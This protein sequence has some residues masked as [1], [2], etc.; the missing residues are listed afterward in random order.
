MT[1]EQPARDVRQVTA[2]ETGLVR[3]PEHL[4]IVAGLATAVSVCG[5]GHC[6]A[7]TPDPRPAWR[8]NRP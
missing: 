3:L 2:D 6:V 1:I 8:C 4:L 7:Q 5:S